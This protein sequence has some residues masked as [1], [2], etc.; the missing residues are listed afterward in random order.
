MCAMNGC[1]Q[2]S[3]TYLP[4]RPGPALHVPRGPPP[5]SHQLPARGLRLGKRVLNRN[6]DRRRLCFLFLRQLRTLRTGRARGQKCLQA[7]KS[8][9]RTRAWKAGLA[10]CPAKPSDIFEEKR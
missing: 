1:D 7:S 8:G 3:G 10:Q 2:G 6:P 4:V 9:C 5:R